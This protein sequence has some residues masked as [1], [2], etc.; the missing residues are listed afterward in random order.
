M[1]TSAESV[2]EPFVLSIPASNHEGGILEVEMH[3]EDRLFVVGPNGSGK[4]AL[5][6]HFVSLIGNRPIRRISAH[7]QTWL[8]SS[9]I[10]MTPKIRRDVDRSIFGREQ[11]QDAR[12]KD[13]NAAQRLSAVLFDL[14]SAEN[15]RSREI[16]NLVDQNNVD[17][18]SS[19]ARELASPFKRIN[20]LIRAGNLS[21]QIEAAT[22]EEILA[23]HVDGQPF[24]MAELSDGERNAIILAA[25]VLTVEPGTVLLIDEP[26]RHLHRS[27]I[28]PFL[29][30]LFVSR[31]DCPFIISTHE[32]SLP[33][34]A[35]DS[36]VLLPRSCEWQNGIPQT[37]DIDV[38]EVGIDL[39][40]DLKASVLGSRKRILF[41]E[42]DLGSLDAPIYGLLLPDT[43]VIPKGS[44]AHV[45][46]AVDGLRAAERLHWVLAYGLVDRDDLTD[47]QVR[48]LQDRG[49]FALS[50]HSAEAIY[51][52]DAAMRRLAQR[53][54]ETLGGD[55]EEFLKSATEAA[56]TLLSNNETMLRLSARKCERL[57]RG[58]LHSKMPTWRDLQS[59]VDI[60]IS[61][62]VKDL[63]DQEVA[64]YRVMIESRDLDGLI[65]RYPVRD[66]GALNE[67]ATNLEFKGRSK[68]E[69]AVLALASAEGDFR[70]ELR[71]LVGPLASEINPDTRRYAAAADQSGS[72]SG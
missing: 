26:E 21:V 71:A 29:T 59:G 5:I 42:G 18:A 38:L 53:Q 72:L 35:S 34:A 9:A 19:I 49:V 8:N 33:V 1:P 25:T 55:P 2:F 68:Y 17:K 36:R 43:T 64:K 66:S 3:N 14:V 24:S 20:E 28:E 15:Q 22:G 60:S 58:K 54:A 37:W 65:S 44:S 23:H 69:Q 52:S 63:Y 32:L 67:I 47:D 50:V 56:L 61:V 48:E 45:M 57:V 40:D 16:A 11:R 30:A 39:P 10:E 31:T 13:D 7:R 27:I 4:S 51:Y 6:Q 46:R 12:W 41:V 62:P 70:E